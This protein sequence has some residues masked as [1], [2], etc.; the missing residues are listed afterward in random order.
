MVFNRSNYLLLTLYIFGCD[1][2]LSFWITVSNRNFA[3]VVSFVD[4]VLRS[5][6]Q[7]LA[8]KKKMGKPG[9][10]GITTPLDEKFRLLL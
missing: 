4:L 1:L 3:S 7:S 5:F 9:A 8:L 2:I 6:D 10:I